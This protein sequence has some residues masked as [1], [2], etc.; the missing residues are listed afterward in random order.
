M[1]QPLTSSVDQFSVGCLEVLAHRLGAGP[2]QSQ[3]GRELH[4]THLADLARESLRVCGQST[5]GDRQSLVERAMAMDGAASPANFPNLLSAAARKVLDAADPYAATT[6]QNWAYRMPSVPDFKPHT[7]IRMGA[8]TEMPLHVDGQGFEQW[9]PREEFGA[10]QVDSYA[11]EFAL[12]ARMI[13][14]DDLGGFQE[15]L[16]AAP[17]R[18]SATLNRL[19]VRVLTSTDL[20]PDAVAL[21]DA[22]RGNV[23][24]AGG[25]PSTTELSEMR[26]LAR[27]MT[28]PAGEKL[29]YSIARVL[30]PPAL[31]TTTQQVLQRDLQIRPTTAATAEPF[32]GQ[33]DYDTE[34]L[35][36][37]YDTAEQV[38]FGFAP[39]S[40]GRG[41]GYCTQTGYERLAVR[42]YFDARTGSR[43]HQFEGRFA[44]CVVNPRAVFKNAGTGA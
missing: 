4:H 10:V 1:I 8:M 16:A 24:A 26:K 36:A 9:Y 15:A 44:S 33:V 42:D 7:I 32:R 25:A 37:D 39:V 14:D 20:L 30:V 21:F 27:A 23:R 43:V 34:V 28:G 29:G 3:P 2:P 40:L 22:S 41:I 17:A 5:I 31:E 18:W 12:T 6:Y 35:L 13:V 11:D 19:C 38:W